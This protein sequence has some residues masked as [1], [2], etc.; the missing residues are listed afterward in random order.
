MSKRIRESLALVC[1]GVLAGLLWLVIRPDDSSADG[2]RSAFSGL[3]ALLALALLVIGLGM[4]VMALL[5]P[6]SDA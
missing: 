5:R 1:A 2:L 6:D 4:L 3:F